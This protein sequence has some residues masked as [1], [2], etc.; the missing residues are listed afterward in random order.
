MLI[1]SEMKILFIGVKYTL[2]LL[3]PK[4][5]GQ[6]ILEVLSLKFGLLME[7]PLPEP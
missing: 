3:H 6:P 5:L 1:E 4:G 2:K 7:L